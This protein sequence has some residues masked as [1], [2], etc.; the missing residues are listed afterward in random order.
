MSDKQLKEDVIKLAYNNPDLRDDLLPLVAD[1][2]QK[3][4][5]GGVDVGKYLDQIAAEFFE[6]VKSDMEKDWGQMVDNAEEM[7]Q[8]NNMGYGQEYSLALHL[9]GQDQQ[10]FQGSPEYPKTLRLSVSMNVAP[11]S[12]KFLKYTTGLVRHDNRY[13]QLHNNTLSLDHVKEGKSS[14]VTTHFK[15]SDKLVNYAKELRSRDII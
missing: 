12:N 9:K 4:A 2:R 13:D 14:M 7:E 8:D 15:R 5:A 1:A 11:E 10:S 6:I 3:E